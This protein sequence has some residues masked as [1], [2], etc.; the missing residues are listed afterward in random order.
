VTLQYK[1]RHRSCAMTKKQYSTPKVTVGTVKKS[2]AAMASR[3]LLRKTAQRFTGLGFRG[4]LRI[5]RSTVRSE[6]SKHRT[7]LESDRYFGEGQLLNAMSAHAMRVTWAL[8]GALESRRTLGLTSLPIAAEDCDTRPSIARSFASRTRFA[9]AYCWLI[10]EST[11]PDR[12]T[13]CGAHPVESCS[14]SRRTS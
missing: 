5:Q 4:A 2:I 14:G 9:R 10:F 12:T 6:M 3:W 11:S 8:F 13:G 1:I 7:D